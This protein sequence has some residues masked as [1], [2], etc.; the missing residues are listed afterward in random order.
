VSGAAK[1]LVFAVASAMTFGL[2]LW[3][4]AVVKLPFL[5][6]AHADR[7]V[8]NAAFAGAMTACV[9]AGGA[10]WAGRENRSEAPRHSSFARI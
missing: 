10:W 9:V 2:Y 8:V 5:P 7:W 3:L 1:W 6:K 4:A